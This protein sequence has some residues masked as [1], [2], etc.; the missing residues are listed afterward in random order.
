MD[1]TL[2]NLLHDGSIERIEGTVPGDLILHV[3]IDYLRKRFPG[4]GSGFDVRLVG[5]TTFTFSPYEGQVTTDPVAV[6]A[7][8]PEI[9]SAE[10]G[11]PLRICCAGGCLEVRYDAAT[12]SLDTGEPISLSQLD[13]AAESY[14]EEWS[15]RRRPLF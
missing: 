1:P 10:P 7:L 9:L 15:S 6:A 2:W 11:H 8:V 13:Q 5:C 4:T 12:L 14:W 3:S